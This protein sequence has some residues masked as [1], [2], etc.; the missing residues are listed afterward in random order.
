MYRP[1][2]LRMSSRA[3]S[4]DTIARNPSHLTSNDQSP[5]VGRLPE[6]ASMGWGSG[7]AEATARSL[8]GAVSGWL[9]EAAKV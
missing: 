4:V 1:L 6:R 9:A 5:R 8:N 3:P 7:A 2:R